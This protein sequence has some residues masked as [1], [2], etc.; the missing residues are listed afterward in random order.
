[1]CIRRLIW[2]NWARFNGEQDSPSDSTDFLIPEINSNPAGYAEN[3]LEDYFALPTKIATSYVHSAMFHRAYNLTYLHWFKDQNLQN[4]PV[5]HKDDGPDPF[6]D[7][8]LLPRGKRH[9]YFTSCLPWPQKGD[10]VELP[11][12]QEAPVISSGDGIPIFTDGTQENLF[13]IASAADANIQASAIGDDLGMEWDETKLVA[14]LNSATAATINQI[15]QAF[16]IQKLLE[17]DAR[18]G[19]RL[20]EIIRSHFGVVSPDARLQRVEFLGSGH[21]PIHIN[22]VAQTS[23][24]LSGGPGAETPQGNLAAFGTGVLRNHGFTKSFTEHGIILGLI[25]V[26]ADLTYQQ[27][28]AK[29]WS[30]STRFDFYWPALS[31]LGEQAVLSKEIFLDG[32]EDDENVFG[33]QERSAEYRYKN[34]TICGQFRSNAD[35]SLDLWHLAQD[36]EDRPVL[37]ATFI[38]DKPPI[39]R[40]VAVDSEPEFLFDSYFSL[41]CARPMPLYGIPGLI[42][43]F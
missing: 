5:I 10:A 9:D 42:D 35:A 11:L 20:T 32:T 1:M 22:P 21:A 24:Q 23:D 43:H 38:E 27:G 25:N 18:G 12:G 15:R 37:G 4:S 34:S 17:R 33:Y 40:I 3:S 13:M 29:M 6:A 19:T 30:R 31:H 26:R 7:Y 2:E 39:S 36:F 16:Q 8:D 28:L 14:D 41:R